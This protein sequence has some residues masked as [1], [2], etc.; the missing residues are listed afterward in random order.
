MKKDIERILVFSNKAKV[1]SLKEF[2]NFIRK[3][4]NR[5][6]WFFLCKKE[7]K[8]EIQKWF[9]NANGDKEKEAIIYLKNFVKKSE[10]TIIGNA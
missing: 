1:M 7:L 6:T 5:K 8:E 2:A 3:K 9:I 10:K 4:I